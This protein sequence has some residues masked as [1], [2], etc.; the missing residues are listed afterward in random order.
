MADFKQKLNSLIDKIETTAVD[1]T[2]LDVVTLT[3]NI[4]LVLAGEGDQKKFMKIPQIIDKY[5]G[6]AGSQIN[7]IAISHFD[8]DQDTVQF[9]KENLSVEEQKLFEL[10]KQ[11][12]ESS[13]VARIAML[14]FIKEAVL[15]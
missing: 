15:G 6:D 12:V 7:F 1:F 8:F 10:H 11:T 14:N 3:G 13:K 2:T 9:V 5:Y 4:K